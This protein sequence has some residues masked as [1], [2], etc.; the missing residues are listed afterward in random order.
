MES[1]KYPSPETIRRTC[2]RK[3]L[4]PNPNSYYIE[5]K[6]ASCEKRTIIYSHSQTVIAC[7]S[8][9]TILAKPSGGKARLT[10]GCRFKIKPSY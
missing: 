9:S 4:I 10:S 2:K 8:C 1:L 7:K 6:C 5:V 3:R